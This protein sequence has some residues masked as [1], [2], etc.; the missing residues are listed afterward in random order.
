MSSQAS[1][2]R[3]HHAKHRAKHNIEPS[4]SSSSRRAMCLKQYWCQA[5]QSNKMTTS[6]TARVVPSSAAAAAL[7]SAFAIISL[8]LIVCNHCHYRHTMVNASWLGCAAS[9]KLLLSLHSCDT[10]LSFLLLALINKPFCSCCWCCH[11]CC[12]FSSTIFVACRNQTQFS[13]AAPWQIKQNK[14]KKSTI[15]TGFF[16]G[17]N[18]PICWMLMH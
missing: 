14:F 6:T 4:A 11:C 15:W 13:R 17:G 12:L 18:F 10:Q 5:K 9:P 1:S 8:R 7:E 16:S 2:S 3:A